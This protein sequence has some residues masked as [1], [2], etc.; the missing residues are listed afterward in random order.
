MLTGGTARWD[1]DTGDFDWEKTNAFPD[2]LRGRFAEEPL[3][4]DLTWTAGIEKPSIRGARFL[5][6]AM[7]D[8][9][10]AEAVQCY[11]RRPRPRLCGRFRRTSG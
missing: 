2:C 8:C 7:H 11:W 6:A 3:W 4:L 1:R 9:V 5:N 10:R